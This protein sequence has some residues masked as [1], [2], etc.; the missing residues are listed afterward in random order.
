MLK[1]AVFAF[2]V[3]TDDAEIDVFMAGFVARDVFDEDDGGV[4]VEF[5]AEGNVE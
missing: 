4:D 2:G 3:F 1:T 5:L